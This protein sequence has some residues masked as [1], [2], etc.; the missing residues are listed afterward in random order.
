MVQLPGHS[1]LSKWLL[2]GLGGWI[3]KSYPEVTHALYS[4]VCSDLRDLFYNGLR[5]EDGSTIYGA[6]I[7]LKGDMDWHKK[8]MSLTRSFSRVGI[9]GRGEICHL[10]EAGSPLHPF[11]DY[12]ND[13][14]WLPSLFRS[15]P[16]PANSL[17]PFLRIPYDPTKPEDIIKGDVFHICKVGCFRDIIGGCVIFLCRKA[18]FD[19][20]GS[21]KSI[22]DR[23]TRAHSSFRMLSRA[24]GFSPGLR[25]FSMNLFN[26]K[27]LMSAP[28]CNCKGSDSGLLLRWLVFVL[29]LQ[30]ANPVVPNHGGHLD[31]LQIMLQVCTAA[32]Q[33]TSTVHSHRLYMPRVCARR[34]FVDILRVLRGYQ[35]LGARLL[36]LRI[37]AFI[38]KPKLHALH[39]LALILKDQL[40]TR[41][42]VVYNPEM[43]ACE[44]NEDFIGRVSRVSR[45]VNI[46]L[47]DLHVL[48]RHFLKVRALLNKR[49][50]AQQTKHGIVV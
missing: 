21:T 14:N 37:R 9:S 12:T 23:V 38:Q 6:V 47:C 36:N 7:A 48:R 22:H 20:D 39:H 24:S 30:I 10:C 46:R 35:V 41:N 34:L 15:R 40:A 3:F 50:I 45:K 18:F 32:L 2:F 42:P 13:P 4:E 27:S 49:S 5:L 28:W 8:A 11:E 43:Y 26:M 1:F 33:I 31:I 25:S 44:G 16:W 17:S 19:F 29:R